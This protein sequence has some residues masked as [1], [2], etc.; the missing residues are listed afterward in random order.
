MAS[1]TLQQTLIVADI[2]FRNKIDQ[3]RKYNI[4]VMGVPETN[5]AGEDERFINDMLYYMNCGRAV[6][7][8]V[9]IARLGKIKG[10]RRLM[11][12]DFNDTRAARDV[13]ESS[14]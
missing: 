12:V 1:G 2:E 11:K 5:M 14:Y 4:I 7:C 3:R 13:L 9:N 8:I 6:N 10:K